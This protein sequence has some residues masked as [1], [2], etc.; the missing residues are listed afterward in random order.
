MDDTGQRRQFGL[1]D[2]QQPGDVMWI[3]DIGGDHPDRATVLFAQSSDAPS[4]VVTG[5]TATG[6]H[7]LAGAVRGQI[8]RDLQSQ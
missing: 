8:L 6:Q 3:G 4:G 5:G 1:D 7:Q 2:C